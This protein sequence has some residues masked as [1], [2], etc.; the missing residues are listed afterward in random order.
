MR[1]RPRTMALVAAGALLL[2][3][4]AASAAWGARAGGERGDPPGHPFAKPDLGPVPASC[5]TRRARR[6]RR[7]VRFD[8][9]PDARRHHDRRGTA[10]GGAGEVVIPGVPGYS[11]RDG[12]GPTAVGMV[13]GYYDGHGWA[14]LI[15]GDA[16]SDTPEVS[17]AIASHGTRRGA[18][19][20]TRTTRCRWTPDRDQVLADRSEAPDRR[21][22]RQPTRVADFMHTSWSS[23]GLR[24]GWSY[25]NMVGPGFTELRQAAVPDELA[26]QCRPTQAR[27]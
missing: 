21:R 23:D 1:H 11:W 27:A 12:C 25:S 22:A 3:L 4:L 8:G 9:K 24:Y 5:A 16:T 2:A 19:A 7:N 10:T 13:V 14:D 6:R 20:T 15:P 17:Q 18:A 26:G